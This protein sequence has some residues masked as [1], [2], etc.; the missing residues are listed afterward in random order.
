MIRE[1]LVDVKRIRRKKA[2]LRGFFARRLLERP[3][4]AVLVHRASAIA[5]D[6]SGNVYVTGSSAVLGTSNDYATIKYNSSGDTMWV[7]RYNGP[8]N[9]DDLAFAIAVDGSGN[10]YVTGDSYGAG[11]GDDYATIKYNSTGDTVWVRRYNGPDS[12]HDRAYAIAID[13]SGNVY[14]TGYSGYWAG[15]TYPD[16]ATIKYNS[17]GDTMWVRKYNGPGNNADEGRA[18]AL[19]GKGN[20]YVTGESYGSGT[21]NDYAT[22]KYSCEGIEE[23]DSS[24]SAQNDR[25]EM[26]PNPF[27]HTTAIKLLCN[28]AIKQLSVQIYDIAGELVEEDEL[29][30]KDCKIG[31]GLQSG[32]Y[33]L[34]VKGY[35]PV[36]L[37][38][39]R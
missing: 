39:L 29:K 32:I 30:L 4:Y 5:L 37:V 21:G 8:G 35:E 25:L 38:K 15:S 3:F 33:F 24:P 31:E 22:I 13:G 28:Q 23:R 17:S 14:V 6:G 26:L 7:R 19:D 11:T 1:G 20:V 36:K 34:K 12:H 16:Y 10:V 2:I 18:I 9:N 27:V